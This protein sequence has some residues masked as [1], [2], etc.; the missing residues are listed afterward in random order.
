MNNTLPNQVVIEN[1]LLSKIRG[2]IAYQGNISASTILNLFY[3][4]P[5]NDPSGKG[6]QRPVDPK[7]SHDFAIYLS[8]GEDALFTPILLNAA[9]H[10]KFVC[11]SRERPSFGRLICKGKAS[12]MDGQHRLGGI[13]RYIQETNSDLNVPFLSFH[14]LDEDEEIKLFD[15]INTK[16]KGIGPS[17]S[18][19]LRRD[20]DELS[21]VATQLL[22]QKDSPFHNNGSITGK[23]N[24]GRHIT[25]QNLYRTLGLLFRD[26]KLSVFSK[27]EKLSLAIFY[28]S[29]VKELF[30][31]EWMDYKGQRLTHIVCLDAL[32]IAGSQ[33]LASCVQ[34]SRK[35]VELAAAGR[36]IKRLKGIEWSSDGQLKY[37]KGM[38]GSR[39]LASELVEQMIG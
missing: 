37:V 19:Y 11:Y 17:L 18:K 34:E 35:Q 31:S 30:P 38:S 21:W 27:E 10:W 29:Q 15:T 22:I 7:R 32:S 1:V 36:L 23:R 26:R 16:A 2:K 4:K 39:T 20:S 13:Q 24:K 8:K 5:Y 12:L 9:S 33:V 6:Y 25:L 3:V 28:F 14:C